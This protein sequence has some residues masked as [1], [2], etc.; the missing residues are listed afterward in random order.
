[1]RLRDQAVRALAIG[2]DD[3]RAIF[4]VAALHRHVAAIAAGCA[5]AAD[6]DRDRLALGREAAGDVHPTGATAAADR[7][8]GHAGREDRA[9][10][11]AELEL[12]IDLG[13]DR[14]DEYVAIAGQA[15]IAR[16]GASAAIAADS[17]CDGYA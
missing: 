17:G 9:C 14:V 8:R 5:G 13:D 15:H 16:V 7:L 12:A 11:A 3:P 10:D 2:H 1:N 6:T 4:A